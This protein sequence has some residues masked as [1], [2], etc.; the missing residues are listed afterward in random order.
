MRQGA[1]RPQLK[2]IPLGG[3]RD[4][5]HMKVLVFVLLIASCGF[6]S[7]RQMRA[8]FQAE[9]PRAVIVTAGVGEG[10]FDNALWCVRYRE[11]PDTVLREQVWLY[12]RGSD[13]R[14]RVTRRDSS[15]AKGKTCG[16]AA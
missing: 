10:D 4:S 5:V 6:P 7:E 9:H 12:Q 13:D 3:A 15:L 2:R 16:G 1:S 11:A 8:E 14:I